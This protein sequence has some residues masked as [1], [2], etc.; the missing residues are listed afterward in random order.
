MTERIIQGK[1][2]FDISNKVALV[3]GSGNG[4]GKGYAKIFGKAGCQVACAGISKEANKAT[5]DEIVAGGGRAKSFFVDVRSID[6]IRE[7]VANVIAEFG[8]IDILVNNAGVEDCAEFVQVT[9]EQYDKITGV[10]LRGL[11]FMAQAVAK[12]MIKSGGGKI[13]NIGSLG[14]YI[15][16]AE[17]SVYCATKG[18]VIQLTKTMALELAPHNIQVNTVA[19]GYFLSPMTQPFFDDPKHREWIESKIPLGRWGTVADLAGTIIF[20]SSPASDYVTGSTIIVDGGW[21]AG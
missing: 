15:G 4:L 10:N 13:I 5:A 14:S 9:P 19:P 7:L 18:G 3:S 20:L 8:R 1:N 16:L 12:E 6:S 2:I 11:F 21:L 17:S